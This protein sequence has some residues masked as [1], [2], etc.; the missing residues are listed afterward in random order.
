MEI[1]IHNRRRANLSFLRKLNESGIS[2]S[3]KNLITSF[4]KY[5]TD[6]DQV[7]L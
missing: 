7:E 1:D 4:V 3:D 6:E 2:D 5:K